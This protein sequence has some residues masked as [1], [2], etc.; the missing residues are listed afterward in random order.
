MAN[1]IMLYVQFL[2]TLAGLTGS[3]T[4]QGDFSERQVIMTPLQLNWTSD[5]HFHAS[6][7]PGNIFRKLVFAKEARPTSTTCLAHET[8]KRPRQLFGVRGHGGTPPGAMAN[9]IMLYVQFL[10]TLAGLTGSPTDQGDFSERQVIMTPL[11][12]NWTSDAHFQASEEPGNIFRKLVFAKEAR[13]TSTTCLAHETTKRPRQLFSVRGHGGTPPGAMA[14]PIML[15]VQVSRSHSL[16]CKRTSNVCLFSPPCPR[17][18]VLLFLEC[19][20]VIRDLLSCGDIESNPGPDDDCIPTMEEMVK[21]ILAKQNVIL[22][23]LAGIKTSQQTFEN[24]FDKLAKKVEQIEVTVEETQELRNQM[25]SI[26][27]NVSSVQ[28]EL[29][30]CQRKLVD[31]EDRSR[32]NNLMVFGVSED[33]GETADILRSKV[34]DGIFVEKLGIRTNSVERLHRVGRKTNRSRPIIIKFFDYN[35]K[36]NLLKKRRLLK[37]T[38]ITLEHDYSW[39]TLQKRKL[40][41]ESSKPNRDNGETAF[42]IHDKIKIGNDIFEWDDAKGQVCKEKN[43]PTNRRNV[44]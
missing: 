29:T 33:A 9:P 20:A 27:K 30:E 17:T 43:R 38:K 32:C 21:D 36:N 23:E 41:W 40:L 7:E 39:V 3:P 31:L 14:N 12:L 5:A 1:P 26:E 34:L 35:E 8:T 25:T 11:Q 22:T 16:H 18:C 15:Y 19:I 42:L 24:K 2:I 6:E 44:K 4:H 37:G 13:P 28:T 10:I